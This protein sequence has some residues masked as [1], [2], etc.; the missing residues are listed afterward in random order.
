MHYCFWCYYLEFLNMFISILWDT[1]TPPLFTMSIV[2]I[3]LGW[4]CIYP[5]RVRKKRQQSSIFLLMDLIVSHFPINQLFPTFQS[6]W[7]PS[8]SQMRIHSNAFMIYLPQAYVPSPVRTHR[9]KRTNLWNIQNSLEDYE[10][11][12]AGIKM[13][14]ESQGTFNCTYL[15]NRKFQQKYIVITVSL[16]IVTNYYHSQ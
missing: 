14:T 13:T 6:R 10:K 8:Q 16:H 12:R 2:N 9:S 5:R 11:K 7:G 3:K 4:L 15:E 1:M